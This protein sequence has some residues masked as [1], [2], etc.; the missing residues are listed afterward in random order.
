MVEVAEV[1]FAKSFIGKT[2]DDELQIEG[3]EDAG[4][5][6]VSPPIYVHE[7]QRE[8]GTLLVLTSK[9]TTTAKGRHAW[10]L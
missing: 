1:V 7:Y 3:W 8:D 6:L 10:L 2:Y 9:E 4:G 5:G